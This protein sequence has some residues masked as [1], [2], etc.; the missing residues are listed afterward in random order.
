[1]EAYTEQTHWQILVFCSEARDH[2]ARM[3][4]KQDHDLLIHFTKFRGDRQGRNPDWQNFV[5]TVLNKKH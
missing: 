5:V 3:T 4:A 2:A 1:M